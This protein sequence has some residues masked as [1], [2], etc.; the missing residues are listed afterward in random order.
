MPF[1]ITDD[2]AYGLSGTIWTND[3]D[4]AQTI[5][6]KWET[7]TGQ[8]SVSLYRGRT[9]LTSW[10]LR[11]VW[12]NEAQAFHWDLVR[13]Y[14]NAFF[15]DDILTLLLFCLQPFGGFKVREPYFFSVVS[16]MLIILTF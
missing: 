13:S 10:L 9:Q 5:A 8:C 16:S 3:L 2:S 7:G 6:R 14:S 11:P 15:F 12:I 1:T 4:L